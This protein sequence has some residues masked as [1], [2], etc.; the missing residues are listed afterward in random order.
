MGAVTLY[1]TDK[2]HRGAPAVLCVVVEDRRHEDSAAKK[3]WAPR[4]KV[5]VSLT[6]TYPMAR[7]S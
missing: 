5:P 3:K 4:E 2:D 6:R 1:L 7:S